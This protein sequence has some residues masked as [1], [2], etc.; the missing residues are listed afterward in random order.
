MA[1]A[2]RSHG[3]LNQLFATETFF[4]NILV[5]MKRNDNFE[6]ILELFRENAMGKPQH[7][8]DF[9]D[10]FM[11]EATVSMSEFANVR[12]LF[13]QNATDRRRQSLVPTVSVI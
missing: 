10:M 4:V 11:T 2:K 3:L 13:L 12:R 6:C 1:V 9:A 7:L 5:H 8:I